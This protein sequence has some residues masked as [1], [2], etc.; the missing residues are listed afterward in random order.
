MD[1]A[2]KID[3]INDHPFWPAT[4]FICSS[5]F[6]QRCRTIPDAINQN[7]IEKALVIENENIEQVRDNA[8]YLRDKFTNKGTN[9]RTSTADPIKTADSLIKAIKNNI[10]E[11]SPPQQII[12]DIT[13]FT[14]ESLLILLNLLIIVNREQDSVILLYNSASDYSIDSPVNEKWLSSGISQVRTILGYS[15]D[16]KPIRKTHLILFVGYEFTRASK[17]I[18]LLEPSTISL[19]YGKPGTATSE[20]H[21]EASEYFHQ[22]VRGMAMKYA[23]VNSFAFS[24][25]DPFDVKATILEKAA[26]FNESNVIVAPM[27]TKLSTIGIGLAAIENSHIQLCYA[28][29]VQYNFTNYSLPSDFY[30]I[31]KL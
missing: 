29:A 4:L 26:E 23:R 13:T 18:E 8:Q 5:S 2:K 31:F 15:G 24:C 19:G 3:T 14:H 27:N 6:E 11:S 1:L 17:L 22:L 16:V 10:S 7:L 12:V 9:V 28:P 30:Y 20:K 21:E 25:S